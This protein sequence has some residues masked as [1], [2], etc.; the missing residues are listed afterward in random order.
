MPDDYRRKQILEVLLA[1]LQ[2]IHTSHGYATDAGQALYLGETPELGPDDP[3]EAIAVVVLDDEPRWQGE[4][5][6]LRL[7]INIQGL[8]RADLE[9]PWLTVEAVLGDIKRAIEQEDR[10]L[11]KLVNHPGLERGSTQTLP[12]ADGSLTVGAGI[13]YSGW[14]REG[15]GNP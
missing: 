6:L 8:A 9:K 5:L 13:T 7:P 10:T 4:G 11:G 14:Y 2:V 15:W 12:R 1:R 3:S